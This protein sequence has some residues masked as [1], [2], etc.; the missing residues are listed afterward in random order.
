MDEITS[1]SIPSNST[2]LTLEGE[3]SESYWAVG[4]S[5]LVQHL[6]VSLLCYSFVVVFSF[7]VAY[8]L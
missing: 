2:A 7:F 6:L 1:P 8:L 3:A 4:V 5:W